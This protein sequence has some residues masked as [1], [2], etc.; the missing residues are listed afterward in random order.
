MYA[1]A[2]NNSAMRSAQRAC[3]NAEP[4]SSE[5]WIDTE[6]GTDWINS[7]VRALLLGFDVAINRSPPVKVTAKEFIAEF[8]QR[9]ADI[10]ANDQSSRMEWALARNH[11][12]CDPQYP[13]LADTVARELLIKH[14]DIAEQNHAWLRD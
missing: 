10:Y 14:A 3:D 13:A 2:R 1:L 5:P 11:P 12:I 4:D 9:A 8:G 6:Q 7:G